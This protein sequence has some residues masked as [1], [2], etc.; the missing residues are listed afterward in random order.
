MAANMLDWYLIQHRPNSHNI[1]ER[2]LR[3][4]GFDIFLPLKQ[5]T[6]KI[7][8]HFKDRLRPLFPGYIFIWID[9]RW[10]CWR[11]L[12]STYGVS[13]IVRAGNTPLA[14]PGDVVER[15]QLRC[16]EANILLPLPELRA[17]DQAIITQGPFVDFV[18]RIESF[19]PDHRVYMLLEM[20]GQQTRVAVPREQLRAI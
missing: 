6:T 8:G 18:A 10:G 13:R 14:V 12:D 2:N 3:R 7:R 9:I 11:Q 17:G 19:A 1:A 5:E 16:D 20:M 15:L 4:Q